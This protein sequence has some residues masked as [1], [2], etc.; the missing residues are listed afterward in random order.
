MIKPERL[1]A[2]EA[3][4]RRDL[5]RYLLQCG[6]LGAVPA[7]IAWA[8]WFSSDPEPL[9][10]GRSIHSLDGDVTVNGLAAKADT[11][12]LAGDTVRTGERGRVIFAVGE[13]SFLLRGNSE[14]QI[15]GENLF[16]RSLRIFSGRLLSVFGKRTAGQPLKVTASTATIG[17]RGSGVYLESEPDQAYVCTCYGLVT[18]ASSADPD[19]REDIRSKNHDEPRYISRDPSRGSRIRTAPVINHSNEE[20]ELLEAIVGRRVPDGFGEESYER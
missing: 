2:L 5:L 12:I 19:D 10:E 8:G 17:I 9:P 11:R 7:H 6:A 20:L 4:R 1:L 18:L 3:A 13:D 16:V 15:E 14:L